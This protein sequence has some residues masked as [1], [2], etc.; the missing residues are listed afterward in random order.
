MVKD[1]PQTARLFTGWRI[2]Y[3]LTLLISGLVYLPAMSGLPIWDDHAL[4]GGRGIG[5]GKSLS[6]CFTE[7][8]LL[9]YFRPLVSISFYFDHK[10]FGSGPFFYHQTNLL[11]H[12]ATTLVCLL[13]FRAAFQSRL[14][15]VAGALAFALQPAQV[16]T[17]AWIGGRT[18]SLCTLFAAVFAW[19][20]VRSAQASGARRAGW[21]VLSVIGFGLALLAK[22]QAISLLPLAPLAFR[23]F[24]PAPP[25]VAW[26][27]GAR[28]CTPYALTGA[29]FVA[30]WF[31]IYPSPHPPVMHAFSE[32]IALA[33]RTMTYY[34][35]LL[36]APA[37]SS[38]HLLSVGTLERAGI[39]S[40]LPGF[41]AL[42]AVAVL[43][44]R[45][46]DRR[47]AISWF[48]GFLLLAVLP[49]CNIL[50]L[51]SL[52]VAPYRVGLA[53]PAAAALLAY[54]FT[55]GYRAAV[56]MAAPANSP[57]GAHEADRSDTSNR[58]YKTNKHLAQLKLATGCLALIWFGALTTWGAAQWQDERSIFSTIVRYDPDSIVGRFNLTTALLKLHKSGPALI[59]LDSLMT[60]LFHSR[61]WTQKE[62][63]LA[64]L[65]NDKS[66]LVRIREN[67][68]NAIRPE[69]WLAAL[70]GQMG[71]ALLD[72]LDRS[73]A[74]RSFE[75]GLAIDRANEDV[76]LGM[77][78]LAYDAGD[79]PAAEGYLY[80]A[81][82]ARPQ[83]AE[84]HMLL[85]HALAGMGRWRQAQ[86]ELETWASL[87][88]WSGQAHMEVAQ[89]R[90]RRGDYAGA[91]AS[92]EF[93]LA[94]SICD[95]VEVRA[96]LKDLHG[97]AATFL[98]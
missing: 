97:R 3:I 83:R 18:D 75:I 4:I 68:G 88:P 94:H 57:A 13:L 25:K 82:A 58:T 61:A 35:S 55:S 43:A 41:A 70:Y 16:S 11:I 69:G 23:C 89:A 54:L 20:L 2:A 34:A 81:L 53:G 5:G 48:C 92:L 1:A 26:R 39:W 24:S 19:A 85:G 15:A 22:E 51:P 6:A 64:A 79:L 65:Q 77:A 84:L 30:A 62:T 72:S 9:H 86:S 56:T 10:V 50:P 96:R 46:M 12:V 59:E 42:M 67:Q 87:Q 93:A 31:A 40:I 21:T 73:G 38:L 29:A 95:P 27:E 63:A 8:F 74:R 7:P 98:N 90:S 80:V 71:F 14:I 36:A 66:V 76:N 37:P 17:V 44:V 33:G 28:W 78:Q 32:Q 91:Q 49:V 60:R 45:S 47:P 52:V